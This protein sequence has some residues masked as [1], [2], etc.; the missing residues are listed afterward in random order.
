MNVAGSTQSARCTRCAVNWPLEW[1]DEAIEECPACDG[2][3]WAS[4][5]DPSVSDEEIRDVMFER[6][7]RR[8]DAADRDLLERVEPWAFAQYLMDAAEEQWSRG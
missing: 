8:R 6:Y 2:Q 5:D 4:R 7:L 1:H 3:V